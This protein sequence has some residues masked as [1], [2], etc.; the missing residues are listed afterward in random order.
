MNR[1]F[2]HHVHKEDCDFKSHKT[3][4]KLHKPHTVD[5]LTA[6]QP[7]FR[8]EFTL[9]NFADEF[10]SSRFFC[11]FVRIFFIMKGV[12]WGGR[13]LVQE[14][15]ESRSGRPEL[16]VLTSLLVS[17]DVK[18]YCTVHRAPSLICQ[19]TSEDIEHHF[20]IIIW[21]GSNTSCGR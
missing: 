14:L 8:R 2:K 7:Y 18:N 4:I 3:A 13:I 15:C 16:S 6:T 11:P 21:G 19:L 5:L 20:I 17:V 1:P 12:N 9:T 10:F